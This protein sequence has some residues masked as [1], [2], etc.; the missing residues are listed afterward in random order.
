MRHLSLAFA[1]SILAGCATVPQPI[2]GDNFSAVTPQQAVSQNGG[3]QRVRWGGEIIRVEPRADATC[4]EVLSREL[5]ADARPSNHHDRSDG[6]FIACSKGFYDPAVYTKGRDLTVT[7]SLNG[8]KQHKV[9]EYNYTFP[10]VAA[11]Q[12][13]LWPERVQMDGYYGPNP[14]YDPFWGPY[15]GGGWGWWGAPVVIV[16]RHH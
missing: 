10:Q 6:R 12:V 14:Y 2:A 11:D 13:Y 3:G 15:W 16:H 5:Y 1:L 9:G 7:G 8:I 4:F